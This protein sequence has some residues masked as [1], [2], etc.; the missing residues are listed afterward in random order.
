MQERP[1]AAW[2]PV[3]YASRSMTETEQRYS[4][5]EKDAL[6]LVWACEKFSD[7]VIGKFIQ[8]ETDHKP[9]VPLLSTT[10]LDRL[11]PRIMRF[12]LRLTRLDY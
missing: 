4:Q 5:M 9:L 7:Y 8:L 3:A 6:A 10:G 1:P 11:P 2:Q 12:R